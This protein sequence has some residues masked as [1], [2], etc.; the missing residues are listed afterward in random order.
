MAAFYATI[1]DWRRVNA[2]MWRPTLGEHRTAESGEDVAV[3]KIS[4]SSLVISGGLAR[5][6]RLVVAKSA[7]QIAAEIFR[8]AVS[9]RE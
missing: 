7:K 2:V 5:P 4:I 6:L 8:G 9:S 1:G 3:A